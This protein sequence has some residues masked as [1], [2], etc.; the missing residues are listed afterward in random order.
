MQ[1]QITDPVQLVEQDFHRPETWLNEVFDATLTVIG[2]FGGVSFRK[3]A[4]LCGSFFR[5]RKKCSANI[6]TVFSLFFL[7]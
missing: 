6:F 3:S 5:R 1:K 4:W 7:A 2:R